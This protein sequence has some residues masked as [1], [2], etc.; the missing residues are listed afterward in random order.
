M[1]KVSLKH[2]ISDS[3]QTLTVPDIENGSFAEACYDSNTIKELIDALAQR[4][5]DKTDCKTWGITPT[6]WR[7]E[8]RIGLLNLIADLKEV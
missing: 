6:E 4:G 7:S 8:I 3:T 1:R 2:E 5:A